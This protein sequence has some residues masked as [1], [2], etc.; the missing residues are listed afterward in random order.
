MRLALPKGRNLNV[1]AEAF[2]AA[3]C[4]LVGLAGDSRQ[5]VWHEPALDCD[6]LLLRDWDL[7]A[8]LEHGVA[9]WGIVGSDVLSELDGDLLTPLRLMGGASR[10]SLVGRPGSTPQ[11]GAQLRLATKY[12][13]T[14]SRWLATRSWT[15][16]LVELSGSLELAPLMDLA[17]VA[18]DI[19]QTGRTLAENG[20]VE[21]EVVAPVAPVV[22][23]NRV[24][25][26]RHRTRLNELF[27]RLEEAGVAQ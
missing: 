18:M 21:L 9:D 5:L 6:A 7:P 22:V 2:A 25:F 15:A 26:L 4:P 27:T 8:Y 13:L 11:P 24:A 1:V 12:P 23:V 20:L 17:D 3:G 19:V 14:A 16:T 10:L